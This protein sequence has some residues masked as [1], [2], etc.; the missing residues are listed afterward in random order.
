MRPSRDGRPGS[1]G[2]RYP[3]RAI[4]PALAL[5]TA[6][7]GAAGLGILDIAGSRLF[8]LDRQ[9]IFP[10]EAHAGLFPTCLGCHAGIPAGDVERTYSVTEADC[11]SCHDG[12]REERVEWREPTAAATNL[13]FSHPGHAERVTEAGEGALDCQTCHAA[14]GAEH[15]M[16]LA[17]A[18]S[19]VCLAC[20]AERAGEPP[21]DHLAREVGCEACH[22]RLH[23]A[24][25]LS[26]T[27][28]AAFPQPAG[29]ASADF[30]FEHGGPAREATL[31]CAVC[32]ARES[33]A[34]C[35]LNADRLGPVTALEPDSRVAGVVAAVAGE[36]PE[37]ASHRRADFA[38]A[39]G[40]PAR[41]SVESCGNCHARPSCTGCH[42]SPGPTWIATLPAAIA[43]GP[44]GA[45]V[46][47]AGPPGHD[48]VFSTAHGA[49][50]AADVPQCGACHRETECAS[51]HDRSAAGMPPP[52][53]RP[54]PLAD[55]P[56]PGSGFHPTTFV[57]RHGDEAFAAP[58]ECAECHSREVFCRTCHERS[59]FAATRQATSG[60]FHDAQP[61]WLLAHGQAARQNLEGCTSCH[62]QSSCLR[63]H[64]ARDGLRV[65]PHGPGFEPRRMA[66]RSTISCGVCHFADQ[67][68]APP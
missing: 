21:P 66:D 56:G 33:C 32:H 14:A 51:C 62:R 18:R 54:G 36:W 22:R 57:L 15:R 12:R 23:D 43:G 44:A 61:D 19:E 13:R 65:S 30:L 68:L 60:A 41:T 40:E 47:A 6:A 24:A 29:H 64:S 17:L 7:A 9:E 10:H 63:C 55:F 31:R 67:V 27:R 2:G 58:T 34:R 3:F 20:H 16:E 48:V 42:G 38:L 53:S 5:A 28:I 45:A 37:P 35:H 25:G 49:A 26:A 11:A 50:A 1:A 39:H 46:E 52:G 4:V 8:S 59:G